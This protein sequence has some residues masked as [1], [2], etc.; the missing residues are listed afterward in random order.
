MNL[1]VT[2]ANY[3][4]NQTDTPKIDGDKKKVA[5]DF[6]AIFLRQMLNEIYKSD[7]EDLKA[8]RSMQTSNLAEL[9]SASGGLGIS[10]FMLENWRD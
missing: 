3:I 6:E 5:Q 8:V 10:R 2:K 9:M 1:D 7:S 4:I